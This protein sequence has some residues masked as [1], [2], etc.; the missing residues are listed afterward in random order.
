YL[1]AHVSGFL[2]S[3]APAPILP[4]PSAGEVT[5]TRPAPPSAGAVTVNSPAAPSLP[6]QSASPGQPAPA[7]PPVSTEA[8]DTH[9][10]PAQEV[11]TAG[12][13]AGRAKGEG[14]AGAQTRRARCG[15]GGEQAERTCRQA[16][17]CRSS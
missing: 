1:I 4:A 7:A 13:A 11:A 16:S 5:V 9:A 6:V 2:S 17:R 12:Q 8:N 3:P 15:Y 10:A 14:G